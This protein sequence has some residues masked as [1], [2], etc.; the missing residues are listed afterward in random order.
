M[1]KRSMLLVFAAMLSFTMPAGALPAAAQETESAASADVSRLEESGTEDVSGTGSDQEDEAQ[2]E[3]SSQDNIVTTKHTAVIQ[4]KELSYT[5]EAGTMVLETGGY[6]CEIFYTAYTLDGVEDPSERPVTF[7]F[8]GGPG[9]CSMYLHIGCFGPRRVDV[10]EK[11][12]PKSM[13]VKMADNDNSLLDRTDLVIIDAVGTGYSRSLEDSEDPFIGYYNDARTMGDFIRQYINRNNR[14]GS[15]KYVAGE[16]YGTTRAIGICKYLADSYSMN[17]NGVILISS[18]NDYEAVVFE[19]GND[20]PYATFIPTY[21]ADAWYQGVLSQ[22]YQDMKLEDYLEEV[23]NFVKDE[24]IPALYQ[25]NR[26]SEDEIDALA[27]KYAGYT[28]L[29]KDYVLGS[30]L[31]VELDDFL[32]ELLKNQKLMVGRLDGRITGPSTGGDIDDGGNDPSSTSFN[33]SFGN[34]FNDYVVDELGF[35]TD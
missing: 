8:N 14:W 9:A 30:N 2:E 1:R 31:R 22:E 23:R 15:R 5:A 21:A 29:T 7:A 26:N 10:D 13:P 11:G 6:N 27:E 20:L 17:L 35:L 16:S 4:G 19:E 24:Y 12:Y 32:C 3:A 28:G 25:G 34:A 33:L 18:I